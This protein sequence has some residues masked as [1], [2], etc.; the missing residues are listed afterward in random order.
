MLN[1]GFK[2]STIMGSSITIKFVAPREKSFSHSST[3]AATSPAVVAEPL[4]DQE[5]DQ[6]LLGHEA[7]RPRNQRIAFFDRK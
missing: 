7:V 2:E 4:L 1:Y 6:P 3:V 5:V